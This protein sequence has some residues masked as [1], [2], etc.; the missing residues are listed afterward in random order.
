MGQL[1]R[2]FPL[3]FL[4]CC[5]TCIS[6]AFVVS[7]ST[8]K[9]PD[10]H[11]ALQLFGVKGTVVS[12]L[13]NIQIEVNT[14]EV[15][16]SGQWVE[17]SWSGFWDPKRDDLVALYLLPAGMGLLLV[18]FRSSSGNCDKKPCIFPLRLV[19]AAYKGNTLVFTIDVECC[20]EAQTP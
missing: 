14:S 18:A 17:V 6:T 13:P 8:A 12:P 7:A 5:I 16:E 3:K 2:G 4:Q 19:N 15:S 11:H 10:P 20:N 9:S 1:C